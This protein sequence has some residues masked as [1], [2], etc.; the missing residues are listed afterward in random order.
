M[1]DQ[2]NRVSATLSNADRD[3]VIAA[4]D[5]IHTKLP[6]LIDLTPQ[7]RRSLAK[8]GDESQAFVD[9]A[10]QATAENPDVLPAAFD[11]AEYNADKTLFDQL[12][13]ITAPLNQ[14]AEEFDDTVLALGSDLYTESLVV[15]GYLKAAGKGQALDGLK[16]DM[17]K[18]FARASKPKLPTPPHP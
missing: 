15:Y 9:K 16:A 4:I 5:T 10:L 3:A 7:E 6:F 12:A 8:M 13:Q 11:A 14:L 1:P 17:S 2:T 18:R